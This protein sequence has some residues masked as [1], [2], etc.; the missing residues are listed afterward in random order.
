MKITKAKLKEII[1]EELEVIL[2]NE[3][4]EEMFGEEVRAQVEAME[5]K[6]ITK[7]AIMEEIQSDPALL[8]AISNL[9][10]SIGELD[11]SIDFLAAAFTG[12]SGISIGAAQRQ[13]GR[14]YRPKMRAQPPPM[15]EALGM[16]QEAQLSTKVVPLLMQIAG[17]N[18]SVASE[19]VD[20]LSS[21]IDQLPDEGE[22]DEGLFGGDFDISKKK[23]PKPGKKPKRTKAEKE[24]LNRFLKA[25]GA[26]ELDEKK[27]TPPEK[28]K[29]EKIVKGMKKSKG[30]F[31]KR[32]GKDAESVMYATATKIAKEKK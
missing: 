16:D 24:K 1:K 22:L 19:M 11:V 27:L 13:L 8:D 18:K 23:S 12:E 21:L 5:S 3:E 10:D 25:T 9:T 6:T 31:K 7:Q 4:V 15:A 17:G 30:D 28:E 32:Y 14:A 26:K 29:K 20:E 2:T